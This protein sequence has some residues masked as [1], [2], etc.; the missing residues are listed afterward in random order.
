MSQMRKQV[1]GRGLSSLFSGSDEESVVENPHTLSIEKVLAGKRQPRRFFSEEELNALAASIQEKGVL[2]PILVRNHPEFSNKYEIVA[3]ERRWRASKMVGLTEIPALVKDFTDAEVLEVGLLENIQRQD[4]NPIEEAAGYH[5]LAEDFHYT[6]DSLSRIFGKSRSHI[7]NTLR[8]LTLPL[9]VQDSLIQ[10]KISA[11]HGRALVGQKNAE[12]L[13]IKII[14]KGLSVREAEA[15]SKPEQK[16]KARPSSSPKSN[17]PEQDV[18]R[19]HLSE[20][21][22]V[23]VD[24]ILKGAGGKL[25]IHFRDPTELDGLIQKLNA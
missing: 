14:E 23:P 21:L 10:G 2:Q 3:G 11:G 1:L 25:V 4:L 16:K 18:L 7:T 17:D 5:R 22:N 24:L 6:Q 12:S 9:S 15:L 19:S 8:L 13:A 20:L